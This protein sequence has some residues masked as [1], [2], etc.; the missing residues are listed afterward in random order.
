MREL[1]YVS[2]V[3]KNLGCESCIH[4]YHDTEHALC[5]LSFMLPVFAMVYGECK[6]K[7]YKNQ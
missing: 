1:S 4:F 6:N 7:T 5:R 3:K 2:E